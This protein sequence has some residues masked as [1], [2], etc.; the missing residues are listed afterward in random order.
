MFIFPWDGAPKM[1][2]ALVSNKGNSHQNVIRGFATC[3]GWGEPKAPHVTP[4]ITQS[5]TGSIA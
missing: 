3:T 1:F 2:F 4:K 5:G